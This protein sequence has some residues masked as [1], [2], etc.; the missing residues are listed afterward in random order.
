MG[1]A[2]R[3]KIL[4]L[5][6]RDITQKKDNDDSP[7]FIDWLPVTEN[8]KD[9]FIKVTIRGGWVGIGLLI[10]LWVVVRFIGPALGLWTPA[11][12]L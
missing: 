1:E 8:Q 12:S 9:N 10:A 4:G 5:P 11:D 3:R 6:P 2:K 7:R